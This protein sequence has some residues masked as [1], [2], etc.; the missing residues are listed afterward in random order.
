V[1]KTKRGPEW[2]LTHAGTKTAGIQKAEF[3]IEMIIF[4]LNFHYS[5]INIIFSKNTIYLIKSNLIKNNHN[6]FD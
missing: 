5:N 4:F 1:V 2:A 6:K 3:F